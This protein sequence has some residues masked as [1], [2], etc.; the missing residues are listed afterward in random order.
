M[1]DDAVLNW[2]HIYRYPIGTHGFP[3]PDIKGWNNFVKGIR[4]EIKDD[5]QFR[6]S[7][8]DLVDAQCEN[9]G[10]DLIRSL[11]IFNV[12]F[13]GAIVYCPKVD[14]SAEHPNEYWVEVW[15][16]AS[17]KPNQRPIDRVEVDIDEAQANAWK[18]SDPRIKKCYNPSVFLLHPHFESMRK[19]MDSSYVV[20]KMPNPSFVHP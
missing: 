13:K 2:N 4:E 5:W 18:L 10:S 11:A 14:G 9:C 1:V 17:W 8:E 6:G 20:K 15:P 16:D 19:K 3:L 7:V 12:L